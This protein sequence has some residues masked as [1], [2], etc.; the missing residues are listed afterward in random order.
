MFSVLC[1][2]TDSEIRVSKSEFCLR[3]IF[4]F[5]FAPLCAVSA[6]RAAEPCI[7]KVQFNSGQTSVRLP[8]VTR[9]ENHVFVSV[10]INGNNEELRFLFDTGAGRTVLDKRI[11]S[12]LGLHADVNSVRF[13]STVSIL[14]LSTMSTKPTRLAS[15]ATIFF[16]QLSSQSITENRASPSPRH[17]HFNITAT[18][19]FCR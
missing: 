8:G 17:R 1:Q 18:A 12:R 10:R 5:I 3:S 19:M 11:A 16:A 2:R 4:L 14:I 9:T 7:A 15:S 13:D 6:I